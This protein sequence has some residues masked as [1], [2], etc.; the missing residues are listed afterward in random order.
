MAG[1]A[2]SVVFDRIVPNMYDG[3]ES[4]F[5]DARIGIANVKFYPD[6]ASQIR[7]NLYPRDIFAKTSLDSR[8]GLRET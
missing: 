6:V 4:R 1:P 2:G 7:E 3:I 8:A 5:P